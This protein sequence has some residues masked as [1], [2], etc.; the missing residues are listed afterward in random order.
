MHKDVMTITMMGVQNGVLLIIFHTVRSVSEKVVFLQNANQIGLILLHAL[1]VLR[2]A[3]PL[4][5]EQ[6]LRL[7]V[8]AIIGQ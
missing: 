8:V 4:V 7:T 2:L 1:A 5:L 3:L 6:K